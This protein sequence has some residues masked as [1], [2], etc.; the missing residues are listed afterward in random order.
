MVNSSFS[1]LA[2]TLLEKRSLWWNQVSCLECSPAY[3]EG[4]VRGHFQ[5]PAGINISYGS[6]PTSAVFSIPTLKTHTVSGCLLPFLSPS[7]QCFYPFFHPCHLRQFQYNQFSFELLG[8][9][10]VSHS[11]DARAGAGTLLLCTVVILYKIP[12]LM[13]KR[14]HCLHL[15][16]LKDTAAPVDLLQHPAGWHLKID[17]VPFSLWFIDFSQVAHLQKQIRL[18]YSFY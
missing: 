14:S 11:W 18:L 8:D 10:G 3:L 1:G 7:L 9:P 6:K 16:S 12:A 13:N 4:H 17:F 15:S 5:N 2:K